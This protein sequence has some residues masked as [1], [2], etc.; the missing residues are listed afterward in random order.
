MDSNMYLIFITAYMSVNINIW[1]RATV[2]KII[3][4]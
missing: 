3:I 4:F 1:F 2:I